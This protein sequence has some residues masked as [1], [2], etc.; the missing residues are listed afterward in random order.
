MNQRTTKHRPALAAG[1]GAVVDP[2]HRRQHFVAGT[3]GDIWVTLHVD[4]TL[5][6]VEVE[7]SGRSVLNWQPPLPV[8]EEPTPP[9]PPPA[10]VQPIPLP[11]PERSEAGTGGEEQ[12]LRVEEVAARLRLSRTTV[13]RLAAEGRLPSVRI[14][15][16]RRFSPSGIEAWLAG[17]Q[18]ETVTAE[19]G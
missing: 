6:E 7:L 18:G 8:R 9:V 1:A 17:Q 10:S 15:F 3:D 19:G 4:G 11:V 16:S 14:G 13:Y 2:V 12:L 5:A